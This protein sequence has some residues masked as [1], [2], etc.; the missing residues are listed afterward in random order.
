MEVCVRRSNSPVLGFASGVHYTPLSSPS[1]SSKTM[2]PASPRKSVS[3]FKR[4][5]SPP[6][7]TTPPKKSCM[8]APTN[9]PGSF[10]CSFHKKDTNTQSAPSR[11]ILS[12][13]GKTDAMEDLGVRF[14]QFTLVTRALAGSSRNLS[15]SGQRREVG[16]YRPSR[17]SVMSN[18]DD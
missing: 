18:A 2:S 6:L 4:E 8:C 7:S 14:A 3:G 5:K 9:H 1:N 10:R 12:T 11:S 15:K 16:Q 13:E 17:L